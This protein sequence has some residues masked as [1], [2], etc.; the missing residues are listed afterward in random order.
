[1][2]AP[3][4]FIVRTLALFMSNKCQE[5]QFEDKILFDIMSHMQ[6]VLGLT[7]LPYQ[8]FIMLSC[9]KKIKQLEQRD[10][11]VAQWMRIMLLFGST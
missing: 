8:S 11:R 7:H 10:C 3:C 4:H 2:N 9:V 5:K 1:M 6:A